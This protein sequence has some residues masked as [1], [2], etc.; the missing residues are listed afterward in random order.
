MRMRCRFARCC[1][2]CHRGSGRDCQDGRSRWLRPVSKG[3]SGNRAETARPLRSAVKAL[4]HPGARSSSQFCAAY[5]LGK[6]N[7]SNSSIGKSLRLSVIK[8]QLR[9]NAMA[10]TIVSAS[11]SVRP[12]LLHCCL[13]LPLAAPSFP[14][15]R[16]NQH[17]KQSLG[18][19]CLIRQHPCVDLGDIQGCGASVCPAC[20]SSASSSRRP[21]RRRRASISTDVSSSSWH[22]VLPA[23]FVFLT[24]VF[25]TLLPPALRLRK[26]RLRFSVCGPS[27]RL[28]GQLGMMLVLP[29]RVFASQELKQPGD[30][31]LHCEPFLLERRLRPRGR[32]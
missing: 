24:G 17:A 5:R 9:S 20:T 14:S 31:A 8:V 22:L 21:W 4:A 2:H 15:S 32:L 29:R 30:G 10:A 13:A 19:P 11:A 27:C 3:D 18:P 6:S 12:F 26:L 16:S 28:A 25:A 23:T 1:E 7:M